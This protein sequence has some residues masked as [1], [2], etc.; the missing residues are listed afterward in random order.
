[1]KAWV[2]KNICDLRI[3]NNPLSLVELPLPEPHN[4]EIRIRI[5][6]CGVCHTELDEIEGRT[7]PSSFPMTLGHQVIGLVDKAGTQ[8]H[9]FKIGGRVGVAWIFMACGK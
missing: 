5:L 4:D 7:P 9:R 1:M 6:C 3:E 2:L 8:S